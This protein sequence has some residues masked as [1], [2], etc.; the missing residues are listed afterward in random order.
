MN[1]RKFLAEPPVAVIVFGN[2]FRKE[3]TEVSCQTACDGCQVI[4]SL[5]SWWIS[6]NGFRK[7]TA[8]ASHL[9]FPPS[10]HDRCEAVPQYIHPGA[11]HVHK[12]I[13]PE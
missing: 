6:R 9:A 10:Y 11:G 1:T 2:H 5:Q 13:D 8:A 7:P 12:L 4:K 3:G